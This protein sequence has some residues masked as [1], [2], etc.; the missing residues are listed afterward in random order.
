MMNDFTFLADEQIFGEE[1]LS[2]LKRY[3]TLCGITDFS[4][5]LGGE[6]SQSLSTKEGEYTCSW[7]TKSFHDD[8]NVRVVCE[9]GTSDY[10]CVIAQGD[11][12]RPV[13]TYSSISDIVSNK[14]RNKN[15]VIEVEYGEYPQTVV[16]SSVAEGLEHAYL[17]NGLKKTGKVYNANI[18]YINNTLQVN[19]FVEFTYNG[20]KYI[21]FNN[22]TNDN[23]CVLSDGRTVQCNTVYWVEVEPIKWLIDGK[24]DLAISKKCLFSG[25]KFNNQNNRDC[26]FEQAEIYMFMNNYFSKDI[27]PIFTKE[28]NI[29]EDK[30]I[31]LYWEREAKRKNTC[32]FDFEKVTEENIIEF[33]IKHKIPL[34]LYG[35]SSIGKCAR[36]K[37]FDP[38]YTT[39]YLSGISLENLIGKSIIDTETMEEKMIKPFWL[40]RLED[41]CSKEPEK[42]H[43]LLLQ[44]LGDIQ[45]NLY[46][47]VFELVTNR[48][49]NGLWPLP[50][51]VSIVAVNN[52][53]LDN[54]KHE[55]LFSQFAQLHIKLSAE[56]WLKWAGEHGIH[57]SIYTFVAAKNGEVLMS[58]S[59][60]DPRKWELASMLLH[61]TGRPDLLKSL[62]GEE[63]TQQ[64]I[65]FYN[66]RVLTLED[67]LTQSY[68]ERDLQINTSEKYA[69]IAGL[70]KVDENNF[71][72]VRNF[73]FNLD[74]E[75]CETFDILW[76]GD[77]DNRKEIVQKTKNCEQNKT[78][79][80]TKKH[81]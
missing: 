41:K 3:G 12:A 4:I 21:R 64:F 2:V 75:L 72:S 53:I 34:L 71:S 10:E 68:S 29:E 76:I 15:K 73:L 27:V 67:V 22:T 42:N 80:L 62:I 24:A 30:Q 25:I 19:Q 45:T 14:V 36:I 74:S 50:N 52:D 39:I 9:D 79:K 44:D 18:S 60:L 23:G 43:V 37:Q 28:N 69:M 51:N 8:E 26:G 54:K 49:V 77:N 56:N 17:N 78:L 66:Q 40:K 61:E 33:T 1:K 81:S 32:G 58:D 31:E 16:S 46:G 6:V 47:E 63:I 5:L 57:P 13:V 11:G 7:W 20:K 35:Q 70:S 48:K 65:E 55:K 38:N 59:G